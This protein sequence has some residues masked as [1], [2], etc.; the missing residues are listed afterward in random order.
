MQA[1]LEQSQDGIDPQDEMDQAFQL[2]TF[3]YLHMD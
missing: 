3:L 1:T 2:K